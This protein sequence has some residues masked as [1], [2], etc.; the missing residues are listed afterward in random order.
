MTFKD[1]KVT[2]VKVEGKCGRSKAGT[3]FFVRN[4]RLELPPGQSVCIFALGSIL[5][6]L[7]AVIIR[8]PQGEGMLD[9]LQEWQCPDPL[10]SVQLP[11]P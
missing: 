8:S 2:I 10:A 3:T 7:S 9:I 1:L 4:A 11:F 6:L 5:Q